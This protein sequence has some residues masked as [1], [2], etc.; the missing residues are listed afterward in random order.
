MLSRFRLWLARLILP[1][2]WGILILPTER[3]PLGSKVN[4]RDARI[5][6]RLPALRDL[7]RLR[8]AAP[9]DDT[10]GEIREWES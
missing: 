10:W 4:V 7:E 8:H 6:L 1:R 9:G 2:G 3:Y 5:R